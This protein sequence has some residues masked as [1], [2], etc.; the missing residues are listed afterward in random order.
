MKGNSLKSFD[1]YEILHLDM[2]ATDVQIKK[3]F[4][5]LAKKYHPDKNMGDPDAHNQFILIHKA[6]KCLENEEARNNCLNQGN[7]EGNQGSRE[8]GIA[9]PPFLLKKENRSVILSLFFIIILFV[10]PSIVLYFY[11]NSDRVDDFGTELSF[12]NLCLEYI[13]NDHI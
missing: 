12:Y 7:P 3:S 11:K 5:T 13:K 9:F 8:V 2:M 6:Y 1:P 4:K 10:L